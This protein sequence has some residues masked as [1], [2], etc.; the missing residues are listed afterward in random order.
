[1]SITLYKM[2]G[3]G[4]C[5]RAEEMFSQD[6]KSGFMKVEQMTKAPPNVRGFP[7]FTSINNKSYTGLPK[8]R[9]VLFENLEVKNVEHYISQPEPVKYIQQ[10]N[11]ISQPES[12]KNIERYIQPDPVK[13]KR[14]G[15]ATLDTVWFQKGLYEL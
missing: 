12:V 13:N 6:I 8:S 7:Y 5:D 14:R 15:Y 4:Y 9:E 3:C 2:P 10:Y 1:M 11:Y